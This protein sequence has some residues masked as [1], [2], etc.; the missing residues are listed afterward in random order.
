MIP[1][2]YA[3]TR[4]PG[5]PLVPILG[6][7]MVQRVY[8]RAKLAKV[9]DEVYV[10]TDDGRIRESVEAFGGKAILTRPECPSG[11]DRLAEASGEIEA[12]IVVNIQGD[13]PFIDPVMIEE[14]VAPLL[15]DKTLPMATLMHEIHGAEALADPGVVKAVVDLEGN[16]LYFS[17]S[18]IPYPHNEVPHGVYEH[19]GLYVYRKDFLLKLASLPPTLLERVE[20]LEQLRVL[21][22]GHKLR[23]VVTSCQDNEFA[24]FSIDTEEDVRKGEEMLKERGLE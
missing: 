8:E 3:S 19:V 24:G 2:R 6:K 13:Q 4:L 7:S 10:A 14:A 1:A 23:V 22:H 20:G 21:E 16:A 11:T 12:D 15:A 5:K 9:L 17:R 18:L